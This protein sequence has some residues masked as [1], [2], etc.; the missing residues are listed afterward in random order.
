MRIA[1]LMTAKGNN[2][3]SRKNLLPVSGHPLMWYP[4]SAARHCKS[5][6]EFY[7]SSDSD[8]I[9][10]LCQ[11]LGYEP[12]QRPDY[13]ALPTSLHADAI[14]HALGIIKEKTGGYPDLLIVL[15]GN[16]VF[17]KT[18]WLSEAIEILQQYPDIT[19]VTPAYKEQDNHPF[20]ARKMDKSGCLIPYFDFADATISTNRQDL[21]DNYFFSHNFWALRLENG[22]LPSEG[23]QPWT[24][25]G[26]KVRPL[27]IEEGF[28]VHTAEDIAKCEQ[29]LEHNNIFE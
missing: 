25:M 27:I 15:L 22:H 2:T 1:A 9:L 26:K 28:D 12:I 7:A 19:A 14:N 18:K 21:P 29:W 20:R 10:N 3:L 6:T 5:I 8:E 4:A 23:H 16:T 24:F 13:L 17:L 11:D